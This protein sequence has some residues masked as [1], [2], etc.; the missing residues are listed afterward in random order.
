MPWPVQFAPAARAYAQL[1][2]PDTGADAYASRSGHAWD[3]GA[4]QEKPNGK[5]RGTVKRGPFV[6]TEARRSHLRMER[7]T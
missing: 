4:E 6:H 5:G 7:P 1:G 2:K 3:H